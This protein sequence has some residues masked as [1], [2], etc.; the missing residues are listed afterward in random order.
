MTAESSGIRRAVIPAAGHGTRL[1]PLTDITPKELLPLG[2][3]PTAEFIVEELHAVGVNHITFVVSPQKESVQ[4]Y[5]GDSACG[6]DVCISY[7]EQDAQ[8]GLADA[9]LRVEEAVAGDDFIVALGDTVIT[10]VGG[11]V[12]LKRLVEAHQAKQAF[13]TIIVER[14]PAAEVHKYGIVN[15]VGRTRGP[16]EIRGLVEKPRRQD[17]PS[18]YAIA[19]RYVFRTQIFQYIRCTCPG[20]D[21]EYQITD[22][23]RLSI[24][25][26]ARVWCV[27]LEDGE[28]RYDIGSVASYCEAFAAMCMLNPET[29]VAIERAVEHHRN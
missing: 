11:S 7:V 21:G 24:D 23:V 25:D 28:C 5:F 22:S 27:A 18:N 6:G 2:P 17:A 19:G 26:G 29:T 10:S 12:P 14:V 1:R 13:A 15:P 16:F 8:R 4:E 3:K 20:A 9:I